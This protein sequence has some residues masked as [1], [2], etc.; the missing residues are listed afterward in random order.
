MAGRIEMVDLL[1][2][3]NADLSLKNPEGQST[4]HISSLSGAD[5]MVDFLLAKGANPQ[6]SDNCGRTPLW[7]AAY[8][9]CS[10]RVFHA[11]LNAYTHTSVSE[12]C[13]ESDDK[14]PTPLW[15][16][17]AGGFL[18]RAS[19]LLDHGAD[20]GVRDKNGR[21]LLHRPEWVI[22]AA[23]TELLLKYGADPWAKD[24]LGK[25]LPLHRAADQG[26]L[27]ICIQL[28]ES[29]IQDER[30]S[31]VEAVNVQDSQGLTPLMCAAL[32]G[33]LPL[34]VYLAKIWNADV[35]LQDIHGNDAFYC[36]CA[37]GYDTVA[38]FLLGIGASINRGNMD[39]NTPLHIA[40]THGYE[41]T[42]RLLLSLGASATS[43]S[44]TIRSTWTL[45]AAHESQQLVSPG[46]AALFAGH[47]MISHLIDTFE[48][49]S[50]S[51][52]WTL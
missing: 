40:A 17:A 34:V 4:L 30:C 32:N 51:I 1:L 46:E 8:G 37:K 10:D 42:V 49:D 36:A 31:R 44:R 14:M 50:Q 33:S 35:T 22:S 13:G 43:Q 19:A 18:D 41:N 28:L 6:L 38:V 48:L 16:A 7:Y 12:S 29:M 21:T 25:R 20:A 15:A 52:S 2:Q 24:N 39:G 45:S 9:K 23:L 3:H 5:D 11:L 26:R 47:N 27:D